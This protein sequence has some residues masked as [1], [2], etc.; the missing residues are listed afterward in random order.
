M[1]PNI[2]A[3]QSA[4]LIIRYNN[5]E[6]EINNVKDY[7]YRWKKYVLTCLDLLHEDRDSLPEEHKKH[8]DK[9]MDIY[10]TTKNKIATLHAN[11]EQLKSI[12]IN[13]DLISTALNAEVNPLLAN[14]IPQPITIPI[15]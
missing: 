2:T 4:N 15:T 11:A 9:L 3:V 6:N 1:K 8:Y 7:Q 10:T 14:R 12:G 13:G 5:L